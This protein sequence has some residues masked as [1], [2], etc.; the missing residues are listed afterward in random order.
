V[1][2]RQPVPH[3]DRARFESHGG[4]AQGGYV[5]AEAPGGDP[6]VLLLATGS[7]VAVAVAA[8]ALLERD[9]IAARVVSV[10]SWELF[11]AQGPG[12]EEIVLPRAV[13]ARVAVEAGSPQGWLRWVGGAGRVV[14]IERFGASAPGG[15]VLERL[16]IT[17]ERVADMAA[18]ALGRSAVGA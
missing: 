18:R 11:E 7:E 3:I 10:P 16:G 13:T 17:P 1:L 6:D 2:T 14:G 15:E 8:R 5:L 12:W 4:V 9:G